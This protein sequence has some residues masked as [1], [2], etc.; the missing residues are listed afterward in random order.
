MEMEASNKGL[1]TSS[2]CAVSFQTIPT[3]LNG[4]IISLEILENNPLGMDRKYTE[5]MTVNNTTSGGKG[6]L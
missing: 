4:F 5:L 6:D 2:P 3:N 1:I